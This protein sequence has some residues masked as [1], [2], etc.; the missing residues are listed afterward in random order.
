VSPRLFA[1][2]AFGLTTQDPERLAR[3]YEGLGFTQGPMESID[4]QEISLL[5][6]RGRGRRIPL[7]LGTSCITLDYFEDPGHEYP[8]NS[9]AA[10]LWFQHF[11]ILTSDAAAAWE[12]ARE[13]GATAIS[14]HGPVK[15]PASSGGVTACKFRDPEGHPLE[16]L[17]LP[18][19]SATWRQH[20][21]L[22]ID[23]SAISVSDVRAC[24]RFY[25][26]LGLSVQRPT[27]NRGEEQQ[28]LDGISQPVVDVVPLVPSQAPP[29]LE[30]LAY[31]TPIGRRSKSL[32]ANDIAATRIV[33]ASD[34]DALIRD[35]DG[36]L[37]VLK[38]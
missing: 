1:I 16:F 11:A 8:T 24:E 4:E 22:G 18:S 13:L 38:N 29:H 3:F 35:P 9:T 27:L 10:D 32:E 2:N 33:W 17:Q 31:R 23:H 5:G 28:A 19:E 36:H 14:L 20:D 15:L 7:R 25:L 34:C 21:L 26:A 6:L 37:H 30:L 12:H